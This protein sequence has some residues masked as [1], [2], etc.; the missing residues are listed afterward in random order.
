MTTSRQ[1][2]ATSSLPSTL[3]G[4]A[5]GL[6][7]LA[8]VGAAGVFALALARGGGAIP[9]RWLTLLAVACT[10]A[11]MILVSRFGVATASSP[12]VATGIAAA[13]VVTAAA[14]GARLVLGGDAVGPLDV[15]VI[16]AGL[17][18]VAGSP[19][20]AALIGRSGLV[21]AIARRA[22]D[23]PDT[24][25]GAGLGTAEWVAVAL[26]LV[27]IA[28]ALGY[29]L[30]D[31]TLGH[32][33]SAYAV[34]AR[35]WIEGTPST[36]FESYRPVGIPVVGWLALQL[37]D[38][39]VALRVAATII[40]VGVVA[41]MWAIGRTMLSPAAA[42]IGT[43]TFMVSE[44]FLRRGT[45]FLNDIGSAGLLLVTV[46]FIWLHFERHPER[47]WLLAAAPAAAATFYVRYGAL[48]GLVVI[49]ALGAAIWFRRLGESRRQIAATAGLFV[50]LLIP[51]FWYSNQ[52]TGSV[53]GVLRAARAHGEGAGGFGIDDYV[54]FF[55][56]RLAGTFGAVVMVVG[57]VYTIMVVLAAR[58]DERRGAA[59]R[60]AGYLTLAALLMTGLLGLFTHGEPR[61]VFM[62]LM[63]LLLV[64]GQGVAALLGR[65]PGPA[66][67]VS[68]AALVVLLAYA[69][70]SGAGEMHNRLDNISAARDV[71][72]DTAALVH[73]EAGG[74][75]C[76]I[77]AAYLPQITWYS[78]CSTYQ[79]DDE[80]APADRAFL[81]VFAR[82]DRRPTDEEFAALV[83]VGNPA[84]LAVVADEAQVYGDGYVYAVVP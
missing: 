49:A 56:E 10:G 15:A 11:A 64:G 54:G 41:A 72:A 27:L 34:K 18:V 5:V 25:A 19:F 47:W 17:A 45:E 55:P 20:I 78:E 57:I 73:E 3:F 38:S 22:V 28:V 62:P 75:S 53:L 66:R 30:S 82:S 32:D 26:G 68:V 46:F 40:S 80:A 13:G 70:A 37:S 84:P 1:P 67:R 43:A 35:S 61:F 83:G 44:S 6:G 58:R 59:A 60:T 36:G 39:I 42:L 81:V 2:V 63:A 33:E 50:V 76:T 31:G 8:A 14:A 9:G 51:H 69:L 48:F 12:G 65:V 21:A 23:Q 7:L 71:V 16:A 74:A 24:Q 4:L 79:F 29:V 52:L 77:N